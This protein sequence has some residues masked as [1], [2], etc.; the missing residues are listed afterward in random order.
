MIEWRH[1]TRHVAR[2]LDRA[3]GRCAE[4]SGCPR[5]SISCTQP[6]DTATA[7]GAHGRHR[8]GIEVARHRVK[9]LMRAYGVGDTRRAGQ[10]AMQHKFT[11]EGPH[12]PRVAGFTSP[13]ARGRRDVTETRLR[14][15]CLTRRVSVPILA[16]MLNHKPVASSE[17][18][19]GGRQATSCQLERREH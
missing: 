16:P 5:R 18:G 13:A 17:R 8:Q 2:D 12:E 15:R 10:T 11:A 14:R 3:A 1:Q 19:N 4:R 6:T 7:N 9:R